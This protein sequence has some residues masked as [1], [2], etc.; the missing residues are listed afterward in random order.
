MKKTWNPCFALVEN[1]I[2]PKFVIAT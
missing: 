2:L 1:Y